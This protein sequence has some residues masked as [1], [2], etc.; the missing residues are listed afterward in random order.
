MKPIKLNLNIPKFSLKLNS[1]DFKL[2]LN[3]QQFTL[4][5]RHD[6]MKINSITFGDIITTNFDL[7][8]VITELNI[9]ITDITNVDLSFNNGKDS[10][11]SVLTKSVAGTTLAIDTVN[12]LLLVPFVATDYDF[13]E[14]NDNYNLA[15][16][17]YYLGG[18][19][20]ADG[21]ILYVEP[22]K[23]P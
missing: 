12:N 3:T 6:T 10:T 9:A 8:D 18:S 11:T 16:K 13:L 4:A 17:I 5:L 20:T 14:A 2:N 15:L 21:G 22:Q 19:P 1:T 23:V 7:S